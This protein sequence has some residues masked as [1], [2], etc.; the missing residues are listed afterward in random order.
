MLPSIFEGQDASKIEVL[1]FANLPCRNRRIVFIVGLDDLRDN[2][3]SDN[4][5]P[6]EVDVSNFRDEGNPPDCI[7]KAGASCDVNLRSVAIDDDF[8]VQPNAG[9][10]HL[11]LLWRRVLCFVKDDKGILEGSATEI[12]QRDCFNRLVLQKV[13][14]FRLP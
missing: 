8:G 13:L 7:R 12:A 14:N 11:H 4:I 2:A 5:F 9:Q 6:C 1:A 3:G 10:E